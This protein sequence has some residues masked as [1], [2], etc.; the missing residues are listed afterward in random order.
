MTFLILQEDTDLSFILFKNCLNKNVFKTF[1][2]NYRNS[3]P[4]NSFNSVLKC[5]L[6]QILKANLN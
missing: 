6:K 5:T 2:F 3:L 4:D 1:L